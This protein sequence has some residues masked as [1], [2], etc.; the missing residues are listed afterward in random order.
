MRLHRLSIK[1]IRSYHDATIEFPDGITLLSGDIGAGKSTL[2]LAIEFGLF[3]ISRSELSGNALLRHGASDGSVSVTIIVDNKE[4]T[5]TRTLR[6]TNSGVT[7][8]NG[9]IETENSREALTPSE[10]R[11]RVFTIL[12]YPLQFLGKQRNIIYRFTIYTPQ[13]EMKA[14]LTQAPDERVETVRRIFGVDTYRIARDNARLAAKALRER[15]ETHETIIAR[16]KAERTRNANDLAREAQILTQKATLARERVILT[17]KVHE[18]ELRMQDAEKE[19]ATLAEERQSIAMRE[20]SRRIAEQELAQLLEHERRKSASE[21]E[22]LTLITQLRSTIAVLAEQNLQTTPTADVK[23]NERNDGD[24]GITSAHTEQELRQTLRNAQET[25]ENAKTQQGKLLAIIEHN[26]APNLAAGTAC[27]TC[28]Q[29]VSATHLQEMAASIDAQRVAAQRKLERTQATIDEARAAIATT[30][31]L[32]DR[33]RQQREI[34]DRL[35]RHEKGLRDIKTELTFL[36][37]TV[38]IK[39]EN[40]AQLLQRPEDATLSERARIADQRALEAKSALDTQRTH[41]L[42]TER[43]LA[44]IEVEETQLARVRE[45]D[46]ILAGEMLTHEQALARDAMTRDWITRRFAQF[47]STVERYMLGAIHQHFDAAFRTWFGKLI[48]DDAISGRIDSAFS[49]IILQSG[50]ETDTAHLSGGER[51]SVSLAWRLALVHSI[52]TLVPDLGTAGIIIL[53]EPTDGFS[54]EQLE[55][56][57]DVLRE[58]AMDQVILVSHEPLLEGFVDH[59]LRVRKSAGGSA[60]ELAA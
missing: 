20:R 54:S 57:R 19:R 3:G 29:P 13:E 2:L 28:K 60:I 46:T 49:P 42:E 22:E 47:T 32:I 17:A 7:Q 36:R 10:L 38:R 35:A 33:M 21:H 4:H 56:V 40:I 50:Y 51:T 16:I 43:R 48:E 53:D 41:L 52:H 27:P 45:Q 37:E 24:G 18:L 1:N 31:S 59:I 14:V 8:D 34:E 44:R 25:L 55:R 9:W 15:E 58:L 26:H 30:Q 39:R 11:A 5:I 6:R 12:G 23:E